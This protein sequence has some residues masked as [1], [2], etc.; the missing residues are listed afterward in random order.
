[1]KLTEAF[2][3]FILEQQLRG[4]TEKTIR[5]YKGFISQFMT[6]LETCNIYEVSALTLKHIQGYQLH[7]STRRCDNKNQKLTRR[8]VRTYMRHI[9]IFLA[10]CF[11]ESFIN[12][13]IHQ[14]IKLP[15]AEKPT[16]EI[17]NNSE[18]DYLLSVFGDDIL[19]HRN[20]A[21]IYL[22][23]DCGLRLSEVAGIKTNDIN[24]TNGYIKV[25]GKGRKGRIVPI[26]KKVCEAIHAYKYIRPHSFSDNIFLSVHE[27][28]ITANGIAQMINRLKKQTGIHRL[29]AHLLRHTFATNFLIYNLGDVYELSRILGHSDIRITEGYVQL[30]SYYT[31]L[32]NRNRQT[33]LDMKETK[34]SRN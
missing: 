8:T 16:I 27:T 17:I 2:D 28:P 6:W 10:F 26:G 18:A 7:L 22:M 32:Q 33:Y 4:N 21:I 13:P 11:E 25:M 3:T 5:G 14:K 20:R 24:I 9:R 19:A 23:L 15:K 30:A 12:E 31:I 1:M 34:D 29:H